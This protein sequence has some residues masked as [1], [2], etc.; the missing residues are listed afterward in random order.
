MACTEY[1]LRVSASL[2]NVER[3]DLKRQPEA[4]TWSLC[5]ILISVFIIAFNVIEVIGIPDWV[6]AE[7]HFAWYFQSRTSMFGNNSFVIDQGNPTTLD[8]ND[9]NG[10]YFPEHGNRQQNADVEA[11]GIVGINDGKDDSQCFQ[12]ILST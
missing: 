11:I 7:N 4:W 5:T 10:K 3:M 8:Q 1:I 6:F 2:R 9:K 12:N